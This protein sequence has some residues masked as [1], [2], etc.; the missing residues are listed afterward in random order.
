MDTLQAYYNNVENALVTPSDIF[1]VVRRF[2]HPFLL[3]DQHLHTFVTD[4]LDG[5]PCYLTE[6][7]LRRLHR[8]FSH[9]LAARLYRILERSGRDTDKKIINRLTEVCD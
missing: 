8:R 3:W 6:V 9:P 4:S 7:E 1:P 5:N 2:G